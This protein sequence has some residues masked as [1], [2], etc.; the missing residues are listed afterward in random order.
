M[1]IKTHYLTDRNKINF[2]MHNLSKSY[3]QIVCSFRINYSFSLKRIKLFK[4][5]KKSID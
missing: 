3:I 5:H 4:S 2:C 1:N